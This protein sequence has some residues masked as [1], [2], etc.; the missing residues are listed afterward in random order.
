MLLYF[1]DS[2]AVA[3]APVECTKGEPCDVKGRRRYDNTHYLSEDAERS[4]P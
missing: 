1:V 3:P 2:A 4:A